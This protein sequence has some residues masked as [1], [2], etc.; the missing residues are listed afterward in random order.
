MLRGRWSEDNKAVLEGLF[1]Q[2]HGRSRIAI[3]DWDN[4]CIEGDIADVVFH[5]LCGDL[6]FHFE[7]P[8]FWDWFTEAGQGGQVSK[9]YETYVSNPSQ[10]NRSRLRLAMESTRKEMHLGPDDASAWAWDS[11]AFVGWSEEDVRTYTSKIIYLELARPMGIETIRLCGNNFELAVGLK[12][13]KEI[14]E[15][16][17]DLI[18]TNWQVWVISAS[19]QWEVESFAALFGIPHDRVV[20]MRRV[21]VG[22]RISAAVA[23]PVSFSDGKLDAYQACV[24]RTVPPSLVAGDSLGDWKILESSEGVRLIIEPAPPALREFALWR[25][26]MGE[27]WLLQ[28]FS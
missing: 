23:P 4:T 14:K 22:N 17:T 11:G 6:A 1:E 18:A 21:V 8:G 20:A 7:A 24:S 9:I 3:F 16:V 26:Q 5:H 10:E 13:R 25:A 15:L 2:A 19:P 28:A 12:V 27:H